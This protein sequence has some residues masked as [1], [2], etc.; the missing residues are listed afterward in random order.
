ML[1]TGLIVRSFTTRSLRL[2][3]VTRLAVSFI[4]ALGGNNPLQ[5]STLTVIAIVGLSTALAIFEV[6]RHGEH[7]VVASMGISPAYLSAML[8]IPP[9]IGELALM[10]IGLLIP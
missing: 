2:W 10:A 3:A 1:P 9:V 6:R 5:L 7:A 8:W 4:L